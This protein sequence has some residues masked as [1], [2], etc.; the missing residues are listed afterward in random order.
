MATRLRLALLVCVFAS[1][2]SGRYMPRSQGR[3]AVTIVS[4]TQVYVRD[5]RTY[6]HGILGGGLIEAVAGNPAAQASAREYRSRMINGLV[7]IG[8]GTVCSLAVPVYMLTRDFDAETGPT[9]RDA[10]IVGIAELGC[11]AVM[12]VG[13]GYAIS[14][15]P[16][17]WDAINLFNDQDAWRA[18]PGLS[19][20]LPRKTM[21]EISLRM[22]APR[23]MSHSRCTSRTSRAQQCTTR[24][25]RLAE[26][27]CDVDDTRH[28][29]G[30][31]TGAVCRQMATAPKSTRY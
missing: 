10:A 18:G 7:A 31:E 24:A 19:S 23:R 21:Q 5:G 12:F 27:D 30:W 14:A 4:G 20:R 25:L 16:L 15:E 22:R 26:S 2:C 3:V 28:L 17:R 1:G 13:A 8:L 9:R 11:L 6:P 29:V